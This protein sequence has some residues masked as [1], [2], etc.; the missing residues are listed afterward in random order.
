MTLSP[1]IIGQPAPSTKIGELDMKK[2][3]GNDFL[4]ASTKADNVTTSWAHAA[5]QRPAAVSKPEDPKPTVGSIG[6]TPTNGQ[7]QSIASLGGQN[8]PLPVGVQSTAFGAQ[9]RPVAPPQNPQTGTLSGISGLPLAV[10]SRPSQTPIGNSSLMGIQSSAENHLPTSSSNPATHSNP[11]PIAPQ[12]NRGLPMNPEV[13]AAIHMLKQ[14]MTH[15]PEIFDGDKQSSYTPRNPFNTHPSFP[16]QP[17]SIIENP[18]LFERLPM[19]TLFLA[20]Y[21]QQGTYQQYLAAK[22]LKKHSWRFHKKYMTWFQRH[23]EPNIT[24]DEYEEGTYVYFDYESGWCQ[25]IKKEFKFEY[26][27]LEDEAGLSRES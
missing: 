3:L 24:G 4:S 8:L 12:I 14:S 25:R 22:Q 18:A 15:A 16:S 27:Y 7:P 19:D 2:D 5:T 17:P 11:N 23:E 6:I 26:A 10:G 21:Y 1:T 13:V 9:N 20:F